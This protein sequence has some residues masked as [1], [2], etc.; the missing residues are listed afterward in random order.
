MAC[1]WDNS[2]YL[3][4]CHVHESRAIAGRTAQ[5]RCKFWC[6]SKLQRHCAVS[7]PRHVFLRPTSATVQMLKSHAIRWFLRPWRKVTAIAEN[8]SIHAVK[9]AM[10]VNTWLSYIAKKCY[11]NWS[12]LRPL[13]VV[14]NHSISSVTFVCDSQSQVTTR[15]TYLELKN[16][17]LL[18]VL[19]QV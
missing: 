16:I 15:N 10:I 18:K 2:D 19:T 8:H 13:T 3:R 6:V 14:S 12:S 1:I 17:L 7:L 9:A 4:F 11:N 5:C